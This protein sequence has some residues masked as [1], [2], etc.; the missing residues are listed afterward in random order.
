MENDILET[1]EDKIDFL[2]GE[3]EVANTKITELMN[4]VV[5]I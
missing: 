3:I 2:I 1:N 4:I 5:S